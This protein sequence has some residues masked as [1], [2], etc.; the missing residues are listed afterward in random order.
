[1]SRDCKERKYNNKQKHEKVEETIDGEDEDDLVLCL[2]M[3]EIK[4]EILKRK[5]GLQMML[6]S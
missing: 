3:M 6:K 5:L 4:K 2:L 1:M